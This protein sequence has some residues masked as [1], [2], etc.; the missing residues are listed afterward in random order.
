MTSDPGIFG[1]GFIVAVN[2]VSMVIAFVIGEI[3]LRVL[4]FPP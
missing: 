1:I 4:G 3:Y 2:V